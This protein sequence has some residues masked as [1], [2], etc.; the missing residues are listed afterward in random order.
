M[1]HAADTGTAALEQLAAGLDP[2]QYAA[3]IIRKDGPPCLRLRATG[4]PAS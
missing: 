3:A 4:G 1:V 2:G